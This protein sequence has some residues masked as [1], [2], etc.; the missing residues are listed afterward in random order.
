[1]LAFFFERKRKNASQLNYINHS[2]N[3][4]FYFCFPMLFAAAFLCT[5]AFFS[6]HFFPPTARRTIIWFSIFSVLFG[7][8]SVLC[9]NMKKVQNINQQNDLYAWFQYHQVNI[10]NTRLR[11]FFVCY[12]LVWPL[13]YQFLNVS[14]FKPIFNYSSL[15]CLAI[16]N[17]IEIED[18]SVG[19]TEYKA[20][21][22]FGA[23]WNTL[24]KNEFFATSESIIK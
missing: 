21:K 20:N 9:A 3:E 2:A 10:S 24:N 15:T 7:I 22:L 14:E 6:Y 16:V 18:W 8:F 19:Y 17:Q 13:I 1:M 11:F 23:L 4:H 5:F 12:F